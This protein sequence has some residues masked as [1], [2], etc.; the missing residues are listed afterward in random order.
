[1]YLSVISGLPHE[2]QHT[3]ITDAFVSIYDPISCPG[4]LRKLWTILTTRHLLLA[5]VVGCG[6][7]AIQQ[8]SGINTVM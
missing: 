3:C 1:M 2:H 5:L 6:L 4:T 8:L 7:Q